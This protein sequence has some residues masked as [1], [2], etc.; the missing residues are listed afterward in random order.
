[1]QL[2]GGREPN[3]GNFTAGSFLNETSALVLVSILLSLHKTY[4]NLITE[5]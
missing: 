2:L 1:M 4:A 5:W 3:H